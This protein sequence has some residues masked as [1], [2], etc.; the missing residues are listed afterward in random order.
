MSFLRDFWITG[1]TSIIIT[2]IAILNNII[3]TRYLGPEGRGKYSVVSYIVLFLALLLGEGVRRFNTITI[4]RNPKSITGLLKF[5]MIYL[6]ILSLI[7]VLLSVLGF[8]S[9]RKYLNLNNMLLNLAFLISFFFILW[10]II[11]A[12]LLGLS[13][14]IRYNLLQ[15]FS[16]GIFISLNISGIFF[17]GFEL[18]EIVI[19][20]FISSFCT[21]LISSIYIFNYFKKFKDSLKINFKDSLPLV[22]KSTVSAVLVYILLKSDIFVVNYFLG[23]YS[24]GIYSIGIICSE[25]FQKV[26]NIIGP[27]V[28]SRT[29]SE[30]FDDRGLKIAKLV[31]ITV[32]INMFFIFILLLFGDDIIILLFKSQFEPAY[33]ILLLL[34][35]AFF[36]F[37]PGAIVYSYF[38]GKGYPFYVLTFNLLVALLNIILNLILVP[39]FGITAAAIVGSF[40]YFLWS[41][42]LII[43]F[44]II[45]QVSF[46][47]LLIFQKQDFNYLINAVKN[48]K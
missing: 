1:F 32:L 5:N 26:P 11:Q 12:M 41:L 16:V 4:G 18:N 43:Y 48:K 9:F 44:K 39:R 25:I 45:T 10:Q 34:I 29:A 15:F 22:V 33:K 6:S 19:N 20:F 7:L 23:A 21:F 47:E 17:F 42:T 37:G 40:T 24:A 36:T 2:T 31:R 46:K 13:D 27:L 30:F 35:P 38:M 28:I 3:I 8:N 14:I